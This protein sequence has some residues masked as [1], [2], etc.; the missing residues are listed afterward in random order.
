MSR[1]ESTF[2]RL[3][4]RAA[5]MPYITIGHPEK[6][7][8]QLLVPAL[9]EAGADLMELGIPFSDPLADGATIQASTQR[10]LTNGVTLQFCLESVERLREGGVEIPLILMGYYNP[11]YQMG[12]ERFAATAAESGADG[13]IVP[14]LPPEEAGPLDRA[15]AARGIA[16]IYMLAPTSDASRLELVA[17]RA[18]GFIYLVSLTGV[19]GAREGLPEGLAAFVARVREA[20]GGRIPLAVGFGIASPESARAVGDVA[21]GVIVGSA[22]VRRLEPA[23]TAVDEATAFIA[24]LR[25]ALDTPPAPT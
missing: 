3:G 23:A 15:L 7:S 13:V 14:D 10:A 8:A 6:E 25:H 17:A 21:D 16:Y 22:L 5:L 20:T 12:I 19:T 24:S 11:I 18:R 1:I 4:G 9:A 2:E